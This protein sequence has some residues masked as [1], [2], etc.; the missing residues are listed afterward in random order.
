MGYVCDGGNSWNRF[1]LAYNWKYVIICAFAIRKN[2]YRILKSII[3]CKILFLF[4]SKTKWFI[5]AVLL[6]GKKNFYLW[7]YCYC[8]KNTYITRIF[9]EYA[10]LMIIQRDRCFFSM[11]MLYEFYT[12]APITYV[13][14]R[15]TSFR[16]N[17]FYYFPIRN[18]DA[19][20][21]KHTR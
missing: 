8:L 14:D 10:F 19:I 7:L 13:N 2:I 9:G 3:L 16:P 15:S 21:E 4:D 5:S 18:N 12:P 11:K 20:S 6:I 1:S 17:K